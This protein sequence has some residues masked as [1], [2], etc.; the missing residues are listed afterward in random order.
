MAMSSP[1]FNIFFS[2][3]GTLNSPGSEVDLLF[4]NNIEVP[5][6]LRGFFYR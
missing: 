3:L 5:M 6:R 4:D 1:L 2:Y